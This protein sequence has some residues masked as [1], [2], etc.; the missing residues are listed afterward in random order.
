M[1]W[2]RGLFSAPEP[3]AD[4][5]SPSYTLVCSTC[6]S[7]CSGPEAHVI[8]WW[9]PDERNIF[10]TYRCEK[11]W[12]PSIDETQEAV[13]S[14]DPRVLASFCDFL[15]R[16]G[17]EKDARAIRSASREQACTILLSILDAVREKRIHFS[18]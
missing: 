3:V 11:C 17:Y 9:N 13:N 12:L 14:K 1:S 16:H 10:T 18:P 6:L 4:Q 2:I 5:E 8:P 15:V 7:T